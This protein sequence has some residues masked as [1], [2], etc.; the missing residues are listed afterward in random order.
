ML[1]AVALSL[2]AHVVIAF[3]GLARS[4]K[5]LFS[6]QGRG[7]NAWI[8]MSPFPANPHTSGR[9][10]EFSGTERRK[11][12]KPSSRVEE[13]SERQNSS[14]VPSSEKTFNQREFSNEEKLAKAE[15]TRSNSENN[16][17][18]ANKNR[19][20][21][22]R[23]SGFG[24]GGTEIS[25]ESVVALG[26]AVPHYPEKARLQEMEGEVRLQ[27]TVDEAGAV[28]GVKV[29]SSSGHPLLDEAALD[30]AKRW[31]FPQ[32]VLSQTVEIRIGFSLE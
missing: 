15:T 6:I 31:K 19:P 27:L 23:Y 9:G 16:V 13:G 1:R 5:L 22:E 30:A 11:E 3:M 28:S 10:E 14:E 20:S 29:L 8:L 32:G 21:G 26:N 12:G 4:P 2:F 25:L 17:G 24:S 7:E 18:L